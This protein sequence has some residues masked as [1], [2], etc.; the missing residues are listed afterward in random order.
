MI[1]T[2]HVGAAATAALA[3]LLSSCGNNGFLTVFG[4]P[5]RAN[6]TLSITGLPAGESAKV[7]VTGPLGTSYDVPYSVTVKQ[8][9]LGKY[10]V[11]AS[12]VT[13]DGVVYTPSVTGGQFE[14]VQDGQT[15]DVGVTYTPP[16]TGQLQLNL[17]GLPSGEKGSIHLTGP[18]GFDR[19]LEQ[20]NGTGTISDLKPGEY[21]VVVPEVVLAKQTYTAS[22]QGAPVTVRF[23]RTSSVNIS[24]SGATNVGNLSV[25]LKH[26]PEGAS[27]DLTVTGPNGFSS[28][29]D[30][31]GVLADLKPGAYTINYPTFKQDGFTYGPESASEIVTVAV[32]AT[33]NTEETYNPITGKVKVVVSNPIHP[34]TNALV[35][36][37][38]DHITLTGPNSFEKQLNE[39]SLYEDV[40][41][42]DYTVNAPHIS[43]DNWTYRSIVVPGT[44]EALPGRTVTISVGYVPK[45]ADTSISADLTPPQLEADLWVDEN[46]DN[47]LAAQGGPRGYVRGIKGFASDDSG[48]VTVKLYDGTTDITNNGWLNFGSGASS[49]A[50]NF[51]MPELETVGCHLIQ[52]VATDAAGNETRDWLFF[53]N[54]PDYYWCGFGD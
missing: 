32:G 51:Y 42:G 34:A 23:G 30:G 35:S 5:I 16:A 33:T 43:A 29:I 13:S 49:S 54:D 26:L 21:Q 31:S 17:A 14:L 3:L 27:P 47:R 2:S 8:L 18:D 52:V 1:R 50:F 28:T 19:T 25:L 10:S 46:Y 44:I 48:D 39:D 37:P 36:I 15:V 4:T 40:K 20:A 45:T 41:P 24:F 12:N 53:S 22:V 9:V 7:T 6:A 11:S 38:A